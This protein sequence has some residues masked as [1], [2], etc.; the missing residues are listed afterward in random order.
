MWLRAKKEES[1]RERDDD[2][3]DEYFFDRISNPDIAIALFPI[4]LVLVLVLNLIA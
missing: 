2:G 3:L 4:F 1:I